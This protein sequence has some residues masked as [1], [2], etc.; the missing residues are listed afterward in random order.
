MWK[1]WC[2]KGDQWGLQNQVIKERQDWMRTQMF[3]STPQWGLLWFAVRRRWQ[4]I[5]QPHSI[6]IASDL[7]FSFPKLSFC[8]SFY[9]FREDEYV[10]SGPKEKPLCLLHS[11][12]ISGSSDSV[13]N[14]LQ[15]SPSLGPFACLLISSCHFLWWQ[16][17]L[18]GWNWS[19]FWSLFASWGG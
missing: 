12:G 6:S 4:F 17:V 16:I 18:G 3:L 1:A 8:L 14:H 5:P 13:S 7:H 15:S 11:R 9:H 19:C 10:T 2:T